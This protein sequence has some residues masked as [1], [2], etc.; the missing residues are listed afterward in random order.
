MGQEFAALVTDGPLLVAAAVAALVGLV[1]FASPCVLPLVP[2]YLSY[3]TGLVGSG[4]A[5]GARTRAPAPAGDGAGATATAVRTDERSPRGRMVLGA[6]LFVLGFTAVFVTVGTALGGLGRL[7]VRYD[8][9]ITR[10]M[11][12]VVI[13]VGLAFLGRLPFLQ[14]TRRLSVRPVAGLAGAPLLGVVFG[15]GWTPC[16]GPTLSAVY[17]LAYTE[18]TAGRGALL[19]VAY[20]LGLG[21]PFVL[22]ALGARW[23]VGATTFLRR[24]ARAVT[25]FGGAVLVLVGLL[26]VTGAWSEMMAWLRAW[27]AATGLGESLL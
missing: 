6:V 23:A 9:V 14:R 27:L 13:V 11:G 5:G 22:V 15:L 2:G 17:S 24:H 21:V 7:L 16:L 4:A 26:L 20:C 18:A 8:D 25:R 12:V 19:S 10:G 1:S 3:V